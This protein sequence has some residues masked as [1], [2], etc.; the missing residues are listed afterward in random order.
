MVVLLVSPATLTQA[1]APTTTIPATPRLRTMPRTL[2]IRV[3]TTMVL[4]L[5]A[6]KTTLLLKLMNL[7]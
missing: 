4:T 2:V 7:R 6:A 3:G 1:A 5:Q